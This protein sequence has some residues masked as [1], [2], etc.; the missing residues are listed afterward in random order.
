MRQRWYGVDLVGGWTV[1][2]EDRALI[3][4]KTGSTRLG[5]AVA[6]KFFESEARFPQ[7]GDEVPVEAVAFVASQVGVGLESWRSYSWDG[8]QQDGTGNRS[9]PISRFGPGQTP[10]LMGSSTPSLSWC[11][12]VAMTATKPRRRH[13]DG[14]DTPG[15]NHRHRDGLNG[16]LPRASGDGRTP[17]SPNSRNGS[18]NH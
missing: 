8:E 14:V 18:T 12:A 9:E 17:R 4:N 7:D 13:W 2:P 15:S 3:G 16:L 5:F 11:H 10:K 1:G 6:L